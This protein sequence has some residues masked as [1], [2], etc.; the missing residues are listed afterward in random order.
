MPSLIP[1]SKVPL[2]VQQPWNER[3]PDGR[4]VDEAVQS[5]AL[6]QPYSEDQQ[7]DDQDQN[8][9]PPPAIDP[10]L[11]NAA[12]TP[13]QPSADYADQQQA[14]PQ[15]QQP[16]QP[17]VPQ[18]PVVTTPTRVDT[19]DMGTPPIMVTRDKYGRPS[20]AIG[21]EGD[22]NRTQAQISAVAAYK[23][24]K[25]HGW[26]RYL[27]AMQMGAEAG[28]S[29]YA[30][31]PGNA[32]LFAT[33]GGALGGL[34]RG[35]IDPKATNKQW[36]ANQTSQLNDQLDTQ[37]KQGQQQAQIDNY[38]S[39]REQRLANQ[40]YREA[41]DARL[42]QHQ[43]D[44]Q[45]NAEI[46]NLLKQYD[47]LEAFDPNGDDAQSKALQEKAVQ[48][49]VVLGPKNPAMKGG[50]T[51][52]GYR[53]QRDPKSPTGFSP[54]KDDNG[55]PERDEQYEWKL[56]DTQDQIH[57]RKVQEQQGA[58]RIQQT[59]QRIDISK[60]NAGAQGQF[61]TRFNQARTAVSRFNDLTRR[62]QEQ[63]NYG[64]TQGRSNAQALLQERDK[65]EQQ[66][67][68]QYGDIT[69][70]DDKGKPS[71]L[72]KMWSVSQFKTSN[73]K[74]D[75]KAAQAQAESEGAIVIP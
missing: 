43:K 33:A 48:L 3:L 64:D 71:Q 17:P 13:P 9:Q 27:P 57:H 19:S 45:N 2:R 37:L 32:D 39:L 38:Q 34:L 54:L 7:A 60:M 72:R 68:D 31:Q 26:N 65:L 6:P 8:A 18:Q 46:N 12:F 30:K 28:R 35:A 52:D 74:A 75:V 21:G 69:S 25:A 61:K 53:W 70:L 47:K 44:V 24:T 51:F 4:S 56:K 36:Q 59:Q 41:R 15:S 1:Y 16:V 49:G 58:Q 29:A 14:Q 66:I 73:P 20:G 55:D 11:R 23:P 22:I 40:K 50:F 10:A 67:K 42:A 63:S 5:Y 62:A